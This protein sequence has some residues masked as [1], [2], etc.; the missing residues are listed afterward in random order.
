MK[1]PQ[2]KFHKDGSKVWTLNG[3]Y[4]R[5]DGPAVVSVYGIREWFIKG[6]RHREDGP[7]I[8]I[9]GKPSRWF[10]NGKEV[11]WKEVYNQAKTPEI[12]ERI[13]AAVPD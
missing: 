10:L 5:E 13:L 2:I 1:N 8:E 12:R 3:D 4:H 6:Q 11:S 7:A 9:D